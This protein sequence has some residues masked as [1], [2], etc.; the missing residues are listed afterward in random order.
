M[1]KL[2][3]YVDLIIQFKVKKQEITALL[4][5]NTTKLHRF[6]DG[7]A[8]RRWKRDEDAIVRELYGA[9]FD[10]THGAYRALKAE[11][12]K[13]LRNLLFLIDFHQPDVLNEI[14]EAHYDSL[15]TCA[16]IKILMGRAKIDAGMDLCQYLLENALKLDLTEAVVTASKY[17]R[18]QYRTRYPNIQDKDC[19]IFHIF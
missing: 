8:D 14:Q 6:F 7:L 9:A 1:Q 19:G 2:K 13:K 12:K 17:L 18:T 15:R 3:Q 5:D 10:T 11:L 16:A 4:G